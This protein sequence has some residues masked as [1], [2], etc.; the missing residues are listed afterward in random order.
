MRGPSARVTASNEEMQ[1][2]RPGWLVGVPAAIVRGP[3]GNLIESGLAADLRCS[4]DRG[5]SIGA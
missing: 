2:T 5:E 4:T 3:A 1:L